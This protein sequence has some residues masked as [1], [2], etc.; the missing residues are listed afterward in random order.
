MLGK[1]PATIE[2]HPF[3]EATSI[4]PLMKADEY[5]FLVADIRQHK[6]QEKI[7]LHPNG[8]ILDGRNRY[9]ACKQLGIEPK[10]RTWDGQGSPLEF[11]LSE[12]LHRRHL[13]ASE[14]G[15]LGV[16]LLPPVE[17]D[18][19]ERQRG[20]RGGKLLP[21]NLEEARGES[22]DKVAALVHVSRGYVA[23]AKKLKEQY[24]D[25]YRK[26]RVGNMDLSQAKREIQANQQEQVIKANEQLV[27]GTKPLPTDT[28]YPTIVIDPPWDYESAGF[29]NSHLEKP[30]YALM[31]LEKIAGLPIQDLAAT[32]AHLYLWTT[33]LFLPKSFALFEQWGFRYATTLVWVKPNSVIAKYFHSTVEFVLFGVRGSLPLLRN[34][35]PS[36]FVGAR[37][38]KH[39]TKPDE[40]YRLVESVSPGPWID[41]FARKP[42]PGW[43]NWGAEVEKAS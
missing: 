20:G 4:F 9:K 23:E 17:A 19:R 22:L 36:H 41:L 39:S 24:P 14:K 35:V 2:S 12:N 10:Y 43:G 37:Q 8:S 27:R 25:L 11:V 28:K 16:E 34:G 38:K 30:P 21:P 6:Q 33:G 18:A 13:S 7:V 3:H 5:A 1:Q 32:N 42:R 40:F 31:S 26:V 15:C 29:Q